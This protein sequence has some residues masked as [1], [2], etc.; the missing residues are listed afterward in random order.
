M[1]AKNS[2]PV[3]IHLFC[4]IFSFLSVVIQCH[5]A[6]LFLAMQE[7]DG[8]FQLVVYVLFGK[9]FEILFHRNVWC[10]P[11]AFQLFAIVCARHPCAGINKVACI[12]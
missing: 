9:P 8:V 1:A 7:V 4:F 11:Y 5:V 6:L 12:F 10:D 3:I 2:R